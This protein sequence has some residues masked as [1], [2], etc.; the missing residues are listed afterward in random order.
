ML[1][2]MRK[3]KES[4]VI[5]IVFVVIVL[6]FIGTIFL[7][8]GKGG[9]AEI[10]STNYAAKVNGTKV[11][12]DE[13][14]KN[15]YRTRNL[16]E[17][18]YGRSLTPE[19]EKQ[20]NLKKMTI[21]TLV[22]S[23]LIKDAAKTMGIKVSKDEVAAEI[24]KVPA[25]QRNGAFDFN[26]YQQ[27]L[28][29]NRMTPME[30]EEAQE[31]ELQIQKARNKVKEGATVTDADVMA[32][33]KKGNDK[34]DLQYV[35]FSPAD[36]KGSIK[37]TDQEL[38][39][40][41]QDHQNEFK[42]PEQVS[43]SYTLINPAQSASKVT[44]S[45]EEAQNYYQKN[46]DRYQGK[47][48]ILPFAEVKDQATAD[49]QKQKAA[50]EAYEKAADA[51]NKFRTNGDLDAAAAALG[52]KVE[53]TPLFTAKAPASSIAGETEL[54]SRA[55]TLKQG[56]LGGPVETKKGIYLLK[57]TD[58]K[59]AAVPPL[60]QIRSAVEQKTVEVKAVDLAKKKAEEALQQIAKGGANLKETGSFGYSP[61]GA[62]PGVGTSP[63][64]MEAAFTLNAA[65]PVAKQPVKIGER[66][67]AVKLK[68]RTEAPTTEFSKQ[69]GTIKQTL[70]PKKQQ[71]A[72][73]KWVKELRAKAKIEINPTILND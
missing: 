58:K 51:A 1:G 7:V 15:Y 46:I 70:L 47:G 49:A 53:K 8:W 57:V 32:E 4:I 54:I 45:A 56:E 50:K 20:M 12:M 25:F 72:L 61:T 52:G 69:S 44:V 13:Y 64:L 40:F 55:F 10:G 37:P 21:D 67:Y 14:Q 62:V 35:S 43:I 3:Y 17:Q 39:T 48:G 26:V 71:E 9:E 11:S 59:P 65:N 5:K 34:V 28:K 2:I 16:Y 30:F 29:A 27:A 36:V 19:M 24:A 42:T 33:F 41:L 22:D 73:D 66:W 31:Q 63:E 18:I 68:N 23:V 6:S 38:T 60:A